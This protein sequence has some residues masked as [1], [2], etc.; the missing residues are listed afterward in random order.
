MIDY[1]RDTVKIIFIKDNQ[2]NNYLINIISNKYLLNSNKYQIK[3]L[4]NS[5]SNKI[6]IKFNIK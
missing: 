4:L 2:Y 6:L 3:Y 1:D 5:I